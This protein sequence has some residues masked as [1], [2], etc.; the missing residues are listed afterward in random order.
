[1]PVSPGEGADAELSLKRISPLF[2]PF[3]FTILHALTSVYHLWLYS[4]FYI[5]GDVEHFSLFAS[6]KHRD[7]VSPG[8]YQYFAEVI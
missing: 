1:M 7:K 2:L 4:G 3:S 5:E 8:T 6:G